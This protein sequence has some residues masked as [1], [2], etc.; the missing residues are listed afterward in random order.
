[1]VT[2]LKS[3]WKYRSFD[4]H[5]DLVQ[6]KFWLYIVIYIYC[7][8]FILL[9]TLYSKLPTVLFL[10]LKMPFSQEMAKYKDKRIL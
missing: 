1:M 8:Y 7:I 9:L 5:I 2:F 6:K 3:A 10:E 4:T